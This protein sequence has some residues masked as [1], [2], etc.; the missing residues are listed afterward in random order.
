MV[1]VRGESAGGLV[2]ELAPALS[3][4]GCQLTCH[5]SNVMLE[6]TGWSTP[7]PDGIHP[8]WIPERRIVTGVT[9]LGNV[10]PP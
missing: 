10:Q 5:M 1:S 9:I 2:D 6:L 7:L 8:G 4:F 3:A